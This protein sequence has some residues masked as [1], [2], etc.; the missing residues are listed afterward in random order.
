M[1]HKT[2]LKES[3]KGHTAKH[4]KVENKETADRTVETRLVLLLWGPLHP[5]MIKN[6]RDGWRQSRN[7]RH[8]IHCKKSPAFKLPTLSRPWQK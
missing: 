5:E 7:G 1:K 4:L 2:T 8:E 6:N 3:R